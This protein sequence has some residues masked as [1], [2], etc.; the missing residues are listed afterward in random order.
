VGTDLVT[1]TD[2]EGQYHFPLVPAGSY[3]V[4]A[5][6]YGYDAVS[7]QVRVIG[8][9]TAEQH[10]SL[11]GYPEYAIDFNEWDFGVVYV[12]DSN[13]KEVNIMNLAG[14]ELVITSITI[15]AVMPSL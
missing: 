12:G 13:S 5:E 8:D 15:E 7:H 3:T 11:V 9:D 10:F 4:V 2:E 1:L 14:G 6:K